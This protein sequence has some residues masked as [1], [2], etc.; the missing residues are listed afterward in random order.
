MW[1]QACKIVPNG[2][3]SRKQKLERIQRPADTS[4]RLG[5]FTK[6]LLLR[7][8]LF[9]GCRVAELGC[10]PG[11]NLL[12]LEIARPYSA[13]L[14]DISPES[15]TETLRRIQSRPHEDTRLLRYNL[16][17][18]DF[19]EVFCPEILRK[20]FFDA[21]YDFVI[22]FYS[23]Q[24][25]ARSFEAMDIFFSN[26]NKILKPGGY[27][28]GILPSMERVRLATTGRRPPGALF[29]VNVA[30]AVYGEFLAGKSGV[31]YTFSVG[32]KVYHEYTLAPADLVATC[33]RYGVT[34]DEYQS[35]SGF[36]EKFTRLYP[37][38]AESLRRFMVI[39]PVGKMEANQHE[40][41]DLYDVCILRKK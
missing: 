12:K 13:T 39:Q 14:V 3:L 8:F 23:L 16:A 5:N 18:L 38:L 30:E 11:S 19:T 24:Y 15:I 20:H 22:A 1:S 26:V 10:G 40:L 36:V 6:A 37:V 31:P 27:I 34:V 21:P 29:S 4:M 25:I 2:R 41:F 9:P 7:V 33:N 17:V 28:F 35:I 32:G